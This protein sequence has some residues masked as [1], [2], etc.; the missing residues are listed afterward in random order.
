MDDA[1]IK[2][3]IRWCEGTGK[4]VGREEQFLE[5]VLTIQVRCFMCLVSVS[6]TIQ[7][8]LLHMLP[9]RCCVADS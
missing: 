4:W 2:N 8:R 7:V 9:L 6:L 3:A 1:D 5:F